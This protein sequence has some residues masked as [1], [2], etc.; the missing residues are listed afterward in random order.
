MKASP[1][2]APRR[3][4]GPTRRTVLKGGVATAAV[5]GAA[6]AVHAASSAI[7]A[8]HLFLL[9]R[10]TWG[11]HPETVEE[12]RRLGW[13]E[14][15][16]YQ[17]DWE[18]IDDTAAEG[19]LG[20]AVP[21]INMSPYQIWLTFQNF[22]YIAAQYAAITYPLRG[23]WSQR[24]LYTRMCEFWTNVFNTYVGMTNQ[25]WLWT[26]YNEKLVPHALGNFRDLLQ[27]SAEGASMLFYLNQDQSDK[28]FPIE[29]YARE[30]LELHTLGLSDDPSAPTYNETDML[31]AARILTGWR[32]DDSFTATYGD[33]VFDAAKHDTTPKRF[34]G[35]DYPSTGGP[36]KP[37]GDDLL[38]QLTDD[39][40]TAVHIA[41]RM[42]GHFIMDDPPK[43]YVDSVAEAFHKS[44]GDIKQTVRALFRKSIYH[45]PER[46]KAR[47]PLYLMTAFLRSVGPNLH[48]PGLAAHITKMGHAPSGRST[49]DGYPT[50][51]AEWYENL[52][53]RVEWL[54]L[55]THI[56]SGV[57]LSDQRLDE[58]FEGT[59][60]LAAQANR[61]FA[62]GAMSDYE[63][64]RI[65]LALDNLPAHVDPRR[66]AIALTFSA[67]TYQFLLA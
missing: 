58:L 23:W 46:T 37:E 53:P 15:I 17:L 52:H 22:P 11:F 42:I 49:P 34:L 10:A 64:A 66:D 33:F 56:G 41:K 14:W 55:A 3:N 20:S 39:P 45:L 60:N 50:D 54:A 12:I 57:K 27:A 4:P 31:E 7:P 9:D 25:E 61:L 62:G 5:A 8:E 48:G 32:F 16:E 63:V 21:T 51:S 19:A 65:Q 1:D 35:V 24:Q 18:S 67:P 26:P 43:A 13:E 30:L 40:N 36:G 6:P 29:N 59:A 38:Q 28:D 44:G 2:P 47:R